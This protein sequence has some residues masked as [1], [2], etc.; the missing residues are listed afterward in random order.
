MANTF[1]QRNPKTGLIEVIDMITG[2]VVAVQRSTF[3]LFDGHQ[4]LMTE[5]TLPTGE[6]IKVQK[7]IDPGLLVHTPQETFQQY[8]VDFICAEIANGGNITSICKREG[9][10]KY[11]TLS[12]WRRTHPHINEQ[13]EQ[14]RRDRAEF[15][16]DQAVVE[17]DQAHSTRDP[18]NASNLRVD[19]Y[20][21]AAGFDDAKYSPKAKVEAH[22]SMPTQIIV[23][24]GINRQPKE[25]E[26]QHGSNDSQI[27][28][29]VAPTLPDSSGSTAGSSATD[30]EAHHDEVRAI[31]SATPEPGN[32]LAGG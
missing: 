25:K 22:I 4:D 5:H 20:F 1:A 18:I 26:A 3:S 7:G 27:E 11:T 15:L 19:T 6:K 14:A 21:K 16:R 17:A 12:R 10:P 29:Q 13:L 30:T 9:M 32:D 2:N 23:S 31:P 24:T 8:L 28:K